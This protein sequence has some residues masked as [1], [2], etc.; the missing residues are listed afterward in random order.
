MRKRATI[1]ISL[2]PEAEITDNKEIEKQIR[3]ES[4]IPFYAEVEKVVIEE[5][6][7][8]YKELRGARAHESYEQAEEH[9]DRMIDYVK[10]H[11]LSLGIL[12]TTIGGAYQFF[13]MLYWGG[14]SEASYWYEWQKEIVRHWGFLACPLFFISLFSLITGIALLYRASKSL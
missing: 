6:E 1:L 14:W 5:V 7:N 13:I 4:S 12:L 9:I 8:P 3:E 10:K 2:V 11:M